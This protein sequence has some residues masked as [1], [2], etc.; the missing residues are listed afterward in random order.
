[1]CLNVELS[2]KVFVLMAS[3]QSAL[4]FVCYWC[5]CFHI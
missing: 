5:G 4:S 3:V 2:E 1:M